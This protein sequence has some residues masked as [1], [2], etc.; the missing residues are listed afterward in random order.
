MDTAPKYTSNEM[1]LNALAGTSTDMRNSVYQDRESLEAKV[2]AANTYERIRTGGRVSGTTPTP[3]PLLVN[4]ALAKALSI[5]SPE[6]I[7]AAIAHLEGQRA[8]RDDASE[9]ASNTVQPDEKTDAV[10]PTVDPKAEARVHEVDPGFA[11][12]DLSD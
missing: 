6:E 11:S 5:F 1:T 4:P 9:H 12:A 3:N 2:D 10:D 8:A 7:R